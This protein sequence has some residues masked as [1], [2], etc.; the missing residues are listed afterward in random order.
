MASITVT[1]GQVRPLNGA[2]VRRMNAGEA[3]SPGDSV[4]INTDSTVLKS[5]NSTA[6]KSQSRGIVVS[7]GCGNGAT[8]YASG[9]RVDVVVDGPVAGFSGMTP[10]AVAY[11]NLTAGKL[12]HSASATTGKFNYAAGYAETDAIFYV[13]G[14]INVPAAV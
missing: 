3:V 14:Q 5:D 9:E 7:S 8:T 13:Q 11:P 4:Y 12:D 2:R 1:A 10:G 6:A